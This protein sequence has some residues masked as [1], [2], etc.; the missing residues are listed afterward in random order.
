[1]REF[2]I[3]YRLYLI[4]GFHDT[5]IVLLVIAYNFALPWNEDESLTISSKNFVGGG[6]VQS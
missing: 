6:L 2:E 4:R 5:D 3:L 1:M